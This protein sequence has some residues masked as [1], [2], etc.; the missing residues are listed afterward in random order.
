VGYSFNGE[1]LPNSASAGAQFALTNP[2]GFAC[3][4]RT[5]RWQTIFAT[6][7]SA[8]NIQLQGAMADVDAEY[9]AV[10]TST[11]AA[12]EA[13]T[14]AGVARE[15]LA[16]QSY[17]RGGRIDIYGGRCCHRQAAQAASDRIVLPGNAISRF[18]VCFLFD[19]AKARF[20]RIAFPGRKIFRAGGGACRRALRC[21]YAARACH[22][23][24]GHEASMN[25]LK[26]IG[27][28]LACAMLCAATASTAAAQGSR[29][30]DVVFG[31]TGRPMA[32]VERRDLHGAGHDD[33]G[34]MLAARGVVSNSALTETLANPLV[35][36]GLGNYF[37][38]RRRGNTRFRFTGRE[39]RRV[40]YPT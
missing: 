3:D 13:R 19:R 12:G 36:D 24:M 14:V 2:S 29:K 20:G 32:G 23:S 8:V 28:I 31:P 6:A 38:T 40:F 16:D 25:I 10:D 9:A 17:E 18:A 5:V 22:T 15:F 1:A 34:A 27:L 33:H 11:N 21:A 30:D 39:S 37:S 26:A 35:T 7:P 4:D